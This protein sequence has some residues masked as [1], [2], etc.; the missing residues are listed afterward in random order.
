MGVEALVALIFVAMLAMFAL[1]AP[2]GL[3][4]GGIVAMALVRRA[5]NG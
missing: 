3:S 2:V 1:G 4:L 5:G